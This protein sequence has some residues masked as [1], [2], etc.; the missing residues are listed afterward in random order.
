MDHG[1]GSRALA[2]FCKKV[3]QTF[4]DPIENSDLFKNIMKLGKNI[5]IWSRDRI[6]SL[7]LVLYKK[8]KLEFH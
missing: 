2:S 8:C 4:D 7:C 1:W 3:C 6:L 5:R